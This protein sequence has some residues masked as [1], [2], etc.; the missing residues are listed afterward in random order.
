VNWHRLR[1]TYT[2]FSAQLLV[3]RGG[4]HQGDSNQNESSQDQEEDGN[5]QKRVYTVPPEG[6][7]ENTNA[8][9]QNLW[10]ELLFAIYCSLFSEEIS[11]KFPFFP[12]LHLL[13]SE[14]P[15]IVPVVV[16]TG[17][18][19]N[20][21][22]DAI[23]HSSLSTQSQSQL[24]GQLDIPDDHIDP[25]LL[26]NLHSFLP[27]DQENTAPVMAGSQKLVTGQAKLAAALEKVKVL[28]VQKKRSFEDQFQDIHMLVPLF[29]HDMHVEF[30]IA[31]RISKLCTRKSM[32]SM[33]RRMQAKS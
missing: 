26:Q 1:K 4:V 11:E 24:P 28:P 25:Q 15:N 9:A 2:K 22:S 7:N 30:S 5:L 18:G 33:Q 17:V 23:Y 20:G 10:G 13:L 31:G 12:C 21:P 19:P 27:A 6:P 16:R 3:T 29:P 32:R 14:H 8:Q